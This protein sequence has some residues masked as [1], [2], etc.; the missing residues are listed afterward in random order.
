MNFVFKHH[1]QKQRHIFVRKIELCKKIA[2]FCL[3]KTYL[4]M[5]GSLFCSVAHKKLFRTE[6][7][8]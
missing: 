7:K 2:T 1:V 6:H 5:V 8:K 3:F 4:Y